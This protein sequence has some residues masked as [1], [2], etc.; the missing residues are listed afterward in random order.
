ML[1]IKMHRLCVLLVSMIWLVP[2]AASDCPSMCTCNRPEEFHCTNITSLVNITDRSVVTKLNI[3]KHSITAIKRG[4]LAG[5]AKLQELNITNGA[6]ATIQGDA[7]EDVHEH[8]VVLNLFSNQLAD[9]ESGVFFNLTNIE[10]IFLNNNSLE[11]IKPGS[12]AKL[13]KLRNLVLSNN[14]IKSLYE[15]SMVE[16]A[17]VDTIRL[18]FNKIPHLPLN[19]MSALSSLKSLFLTNNN[20]SFLHDEPGLN[21]PNLETLE[22]DSNP[23]EIMGQFPKIGENLKTV[24]LGFTNI[25]MTDQST[26]TNL[27][28]L[29]T[30]V[31]DQTHISI[32]HSG[33]FFGLNNVSDLLLLN[34]HD[35]ETV[36]P[37]AFHGLDNLR[38]VD[39]R[40]SKRLSFIDE[41]AFMSTPAIQFLFLHKC[42]LTS[43]PENLV[44]WDR[45]T[46][47]T[48]GDNPINC[49]C[50]MKWV[51]DDAQYGTN[52]AIKDEL[53]SIVC[54]QP[55][56]FKGRKI[57]TLVASNLSCPE[58]EHKARAVTGIIVAIICVSIVALFAL[59]FKFRKQILSRCR[60]YYQYRRY[61][62]DM[63]FTVDQDTS[64]AEL[65]DT[66]D[67]KPLANLKLE[68]SAD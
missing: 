14:K 1:G 54:A 40:N 6:L 26:W 49:D 8:L 43:I 34:M 53:Q 4:D 19:N 5:F 12:F 30:L 45:L 41:T 28:G 3:T 61:H 59:L 24:N 16:M 44:K 23:L 60:R 15:N 55:A 25:R 42:S 50:K 11:V 21:F 22:L 39:L 62:S 64:I 9:I 18:E 67:T 47:V 17:M 66:V 7:F 27:K 63:I 38:N 56:P 68:Q 35:L 51:L 58:M 36:G 37:D 33:M 31:L 57:G 48:V 52:T 10:H 32:L 13:P 20:I 2:L 29:K 46:Q 65:E